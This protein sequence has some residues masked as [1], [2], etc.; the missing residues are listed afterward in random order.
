MEDHYLKMLDAS[1]SLAIYG[2]ALS[3]ETEVEVDE[4][5]A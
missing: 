2:S 4:P 3:D 1:A 5:Y